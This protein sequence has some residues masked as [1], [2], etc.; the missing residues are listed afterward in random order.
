MMPHVT[1]PVGSSGQAGGFSWWSVGSSMTG[2]FSGAG[3]RLP[4]WHAM[5][6]FAI[7]LIHSASNGKGMSRR[8]PRPPRRMLPVATPDAARRKLGEAPQR[9]GRKVAAE[10]DGTVKRRKHQHRSTQGGAAQRCLER[11]MWADSLE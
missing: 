5:G 3:G 6:G 1:P 8:P 9:G 11:L 7:K 10:L 2:R 4:I